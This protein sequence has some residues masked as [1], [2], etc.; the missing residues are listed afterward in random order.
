LTEGSLEREPFGLGEGAG[1]GTGG[2]SRGKFEEAAGGTLFLDEIGEISAKLQLEL[3][4]VLEGGELRRASGGRPPHGD[5]RVIATSQCDLKQ[6]SESGAFRRELYYRLNAIPITLPPLRERKEDIPLL[7][8]HFLRQFRAQAEK[9]LEGV[10]AEA[11][12]LFLGYEWPGNV[13]ELRSVLER[14]S[15]LVRGPILTPTDLEF[16]FPSLPARER[17]AAAGAD[18]LREVERRHIASTLL[19]HGWN[20]SRSAKALGIDRVTLYNKIKRYHIRE[21]G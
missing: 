9:P 13:R 20:I 10:S 7:V 12:E 8:D 17:G 6:R 11:M 4:R 2:T 3:L 1:T 5:A 19:A 21:E 16:A 14:A 15:V 18:S